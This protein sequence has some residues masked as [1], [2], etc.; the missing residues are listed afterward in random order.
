[1]RAAIEVLPLLLLPLRVLMLP[2]L[3]FVRLGLR[4]ALSRDARLVPL[5]APQLFSC[6]RC[7]R[8]ACS[9]LARIPLYPLLLLLLLLLLP[10]L[11]LPLLLLFMLLLALSCEAFPT[12]PRSVQA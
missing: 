4:F 2:L 7:I 6:G 3:G 8:A 9:K 11:P 10:P 5:A 12:P 1:V